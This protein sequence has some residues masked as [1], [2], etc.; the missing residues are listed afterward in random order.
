MENIKIKDLHIGNA[1][2]IT[3]ASNKGFENYFYTDNR[4]YESLVNNKEKYIIAGKKGTGKTLL[5]KYY[6]SL[7]NR[8][9]NPSVVITIERNYYLQKLIELGN[10]ISREYKYGYKGFNW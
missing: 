6:E 1:N 5:A 2:G 8:K 9:G 7:E 4:Y 10:L 3:E